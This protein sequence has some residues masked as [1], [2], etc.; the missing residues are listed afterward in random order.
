MSLSIQPT[1]ATVWQVV[2]RDYPARIRLSTS[3]KD[4]DGNYINS[5]W[6]ASL[7]GEAFRKVDILPNAKTRIKILRGMVEH[8]SVKQKDDSYKN[9]VNLTIFDF[10]LAESGNA[11]PQTSRPQPSQQHAPQQNSYNNSQQQE[12]QYVADDYPF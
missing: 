7:F 12:E 8:I 5:N 6:F 4:Q 10:E 1:Y 11:S 9:Y 2:R 3:R